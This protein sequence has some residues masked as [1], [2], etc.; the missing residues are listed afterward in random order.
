MRELSGSSTTKYVNFY[1][2][3]DDHGNI[4]EA[5]MGNLKLEI[6]LTFDGEEGHD[7]GDEELC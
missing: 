2:E 4:E 1:D 5:D 3:G 7:G 6:S